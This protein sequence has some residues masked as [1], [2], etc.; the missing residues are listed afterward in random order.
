MIFNKPNFVGEGEKKKGPL[1][2]RKKKGPL[3]HSEK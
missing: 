3:G 2:H 1:G